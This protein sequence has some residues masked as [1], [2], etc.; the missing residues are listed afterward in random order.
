M[1]RSMFTAAAAS[2]VYLT[3]GGIPFDYGLAAFLSGLIWTMLGQARRRPSLP[4]AARMERAHLVLAAQR[5][6]LLLRRPAC[7]GAWIA[8]TVCGPWHPKCAGH[9]AQVACFW[10]MR[11]LNRRSVIIIAMAALMLISMVVIYYEAVESTIE[12]I[13]DHKLWAWGAICSGARSLTPSSATDA[14]AVQEHAI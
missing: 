11:L 10:L 3:F 5:I 12:S 4:C 14:T 7:S 2:V 8:C 13:R 6:L 9:S 1:P